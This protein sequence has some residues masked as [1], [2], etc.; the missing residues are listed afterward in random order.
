MTRRDSA[1]SFPM[2]SPSNSKDYLSRLGSTPV[3]SNRRDRRKRAGIMVTPKRVVSRVLVK[4]KHSILELNDD[5]LIYIFRYVSIYDLVALCQTCNRLKEITYRDILWKRHYLAL[6]Y[7]SR[8]HVLPHVGLRCSIMIQ[9]GEKICINYAHF[10][11][12]Q[13]GKLPILSPGYRMKAIRRLYHLRLKYISN[14]IGSLVSTF[15]I[16]YYVQEV[17]KKIMEQAARNEREI[18]KRFRHIEYH[19]E[20]EEI[21]AD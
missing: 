14:H 7:G 5:C 1:I 21:I 9:H 4:V 16:K 8:I 12:P 19:K 6:F 18:H 17:Q 15:K 11:E 3:R 10:I 13:D 20:E 2:E